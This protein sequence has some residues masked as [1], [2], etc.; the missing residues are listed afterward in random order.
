M[1]T[2]NRAATN[3]KSDEYWLE[4][5]ERL[6]RLE[7]NEDYLKVIH[8]GFLIESALDNVEAL[9]TVTDEGGREAV[10]EELVS[11]SILMKRLKAIKMFGELVRQDQS[12][13]K[14]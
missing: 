5:L 6:E 8:D 3:D 12:E 11:I 1:S 9:T 10:V 2:I 7:R 13:F 14:D 4:Q